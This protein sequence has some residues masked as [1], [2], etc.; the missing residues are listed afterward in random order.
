MLFDAA[1]S[2]GVPLFGPAVSA[3]P[4]EFTEIP[5]ETFSKAD[6]G[7]AFP[8][9][10]DWFRSDYTTGQ[11]S[12]SRGAAGL[13]ARGGRSHLYEAGADDDGGSFSLVDKAGSGAG[14]SGRG[15]SG[16][17]GPNFGQRG[18]RGGYASRGGARGGAGGA[19]GGAAGGYNNRGSG[20]GGRGRGTQYLGRGGYGRM[21]NSRWGD[22]QQRDRNATV[23]VRSS[24]EKLEEIDF[25]RLSKLR[26]DVDTQ[27]PEDIGQF[28]FVTEYDRSYDRVNTKNPVPLQVI[29]R[30]HYNP[31]TS[32]DPIIQEVRLPNLC[33]VEYCT[34]IVRTQYAA[35]NRAT[36]FATDNILSLLMCTSRSSNPWDIVITREGDKVFLDKREV[37]DGP[38][39]KCMFGTLEYMLTD[40]LPDLVSVNENASDPPMDAERPKDVKEQDFKDINSPSALAL[41]ATYVNN[42]FAWQVVKD[43]AGDASRIDFAKPNPF[44]SSEEVNPPA[45]CGYRYRKFDLSINEEED[46]TLIVR[47]EVDS[48]IRGTPTAT[49]SITTSDFNRPD[50][51][52]VTYI[53]TKTLFEYK[54]RSGQGA[55]GAPDWRSKLDTQ[56]GA[57]V[58]TEMK[59]N[60][61]KLARFAVQSIL[62]G[63]EQMKMGYISRANV[64]DDNRHVILGTQWL[65]PR[66]FA[67]QMNVNL[68]NGWGIVRTIVDLVLKQPEGKFCL[69]RD[70]NSAKIHLYRVPF[71]AFEPVDEDET[72]E[73]ERNGSADESDRDGFTLV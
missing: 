48:Y 7:H 11:G 46:V 59:N 31:T 47:T 14:R 49:S 2:S 15:G 22:H 37:E 25:A 1:S 57:V 52:E 73:A 26:L 39:G 72:E 41:E 42:T 43:D 13:A 66:E 18:G 68:P 53:T 64:K 69:L 23:A 10:A 65:K 60:S 20:Y 44:Y 67:S 16:I 40:I 8:Q 17:G 45:S 12:S 58:A 32:D 9:P 55:G 33:S 54:G 30:V 4:S 19:R 38:F 63:A 6:R 62:A 61:C 24:W 36:I 51:S 5:Y 56:R 35:A 71:D 3:I 21:G 34:N 27:D 70:P 29:D 50:A 28:G